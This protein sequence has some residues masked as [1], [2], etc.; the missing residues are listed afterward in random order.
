LTT[1]TPNR[2]WYHLTPDRFVVGLLVVQVFLLLSERFE[3]FAFN[4]KKGWTVLIA[5]GVVGLAVLVTLGWGLICL[6]LRQRFQF[7]FRS[8]LVFFVAASVPLGWLAWEMQKARRQREAVG[9]IM[10]AGGV[11][12]YD[13]EPR[14][15]GGVV[16]LER[17]TTPTWL[18]KLLGDDFFC[19]VVV[20]DCSAKNFDDVDA[21]HLQE[22]PNLEWLLLGHTQ[23]TDNGLAHM[24]GMTQLKALSLDGTK[25]TDD[26]LVHLEKMTQLEEL[27][28]EGTQITDKGLAHLDGMTN[29][30]ALSL[31][32][33]QISDNGL[34][35]LENMTKLELLSLGRTQI[36]DSG[37]AHLEGLTKL[38]H[39]YL[40]FTQISDS[41]LAH[42]EGLIELESLSLKD[43]QITDNGV[44]KL[45]R[46]LPNCRI[47][48][49]HA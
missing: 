10:E 43:T 25:I 12:F 26:G 48:H 30:E 35:H 39:L 15:I 49:W 9:A 8:L 19:G 4:E 33:T 41:G 29:L 27:W 11:V 20:V 2:R 14:H 31:D 40:D 42:L 36:S 32:G 6:L 47:V 28:L 38:T 21:M 7:G 13:Y 44:K 46:A 22:L 1:A 23:I 34:A 5:V 37:L 16:V 45:Q 17:P 3:W 24:K 18:R